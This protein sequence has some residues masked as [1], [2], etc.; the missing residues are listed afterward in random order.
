MTKLTCPSCNTVLKLSVPVAAGKK[1]KCPR[2]AAVF[3]MAAEEEV[4]ARV[5]ATK[6][7][8]AK[9]PAPSARTSPPSDASAFQKEARAPA[10][11]P[12]LERVST[13]EPEDDEDRPRRSATKGRTKKSNAPLVW[14]LVGGGVG[15]L[16]LAGGVVLALSGYFGKSPS[17][18]PVASAPVV[19]DKLPQPVPPEVPDEP[20]DP[21]EPARGFASPDEAMDAY[22]DALRNQK[23]DAFKTAVGGNRLRLFENQVAGL[24][25][26]AE[27]GPAVE[28]AWKQVFAI[29]RNME[30]L[31]TPHKR[32]PAEL[33]GPNRA[34][35]IVLTE[36]VFRKN[37]L[38]Y[39]KYVFS[40]RKDLW[41]QTNIET[42]KS[43]N[44]PPGKYR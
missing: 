5:T 25:G 4:E 32:F 7:A 20:D 24:A 44:L 33:Q 34:F 30:A 37:D 27:Q 36:G 22:L 11:K 13:V 10:A 38:M 43:S 26:G 41:R 42:G 40:R 23:V 6:P 21:D 15:L 18:Q 2:C 8:P 31:D 14:G 35:I 16:L 1:I 12:R 9:A 3:P 39:T 17:T 29:A 28:A 19:N